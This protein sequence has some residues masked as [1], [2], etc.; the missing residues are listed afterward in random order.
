MVKAWT[1]ETDQP[2]ISFEYFP[3]RT[4]EGIAKVRRPADLIC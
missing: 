1:A 2:F 4:E 3:P